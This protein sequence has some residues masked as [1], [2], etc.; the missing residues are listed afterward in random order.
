MPQLTVRITFTHQ[1]VVTASAN[2]GSNEEFTNLA[3]LLNQNFSYA[4]ND[5][6]AMVEVISPGPV[7]D[8]MQQRLMA[9]KGYIAYPFKRYAC[10]DGGMG[11]GH[12]R[13]QVNSQSV[14]RIYACSVDYTPTR[15]VVSSETT[16]AVGDAEVGTVAQLYSTR[17]L[18]SRVRTGSGLGDTDGGEYYFTLAGIPPLLGRLVLDHQMQPAQAP[19]ARGRRAGDVRQLPAVAQQRVPDLHAAV[20][21]ELRPQ[22]HLGA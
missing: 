12:V 21:P 7:Y 19:P 14:D 4:I 1:P 9:A 6:Y 20:R 2:S 11:E 10:F 13:F 5:A 8:Q 15:G 3:G 17:A 22:A 16:V 18:R